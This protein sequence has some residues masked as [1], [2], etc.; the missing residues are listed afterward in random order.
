M[1][2]GCAKANQKQQQHQILQFVILENTGKIKDARERPVQTP[3]HLKPLSTS[4]SGIIELAI[5]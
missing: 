1:E 2:E 4:K 3:A 5:P